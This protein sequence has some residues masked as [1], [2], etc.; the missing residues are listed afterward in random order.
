[1]NF[2]KFILIIALCN[3]TLSAIAQ[4]TL[5]PISI[6]ANYSFNGSGDAGGFLINLDYTK[7]LN[8][9]FD[10]IYNLGFSVHAV[11]AYPGEEPNDP[12]IPDDLQTEVP[13]WVTSGVQLSSVLFYKF[14]QKKSSG[15]KIG[16]GPVIRL[17][18][19][20]SP[21][22]YGYYS[23]YPSFP[24]PFYVIKETDKAFLNVGYHIRLMYDFKPIRRYYF[25]LNAFY[26]N[27]TNGDLLV[28]VGV[29]YTFLF[30]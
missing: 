19:N 10:L 5:F 14:N 9:R 16:I 23:G 20:S 29:R 26:Q 8:K 13:L 11:R 3:S 24:Q 15:L 17:Q 22:S 27:D 2:I 7:K 30:K 1:M 4:D 6:G 18:L 12:T 21:I 25:G 28:G